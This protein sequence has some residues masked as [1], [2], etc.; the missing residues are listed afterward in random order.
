MTYCVAFL[1]LFGVVSCKKL[2]TF[3]PEE[4]AKNALIESLQ[5]SLDS[6]SVQSQNS[7]LMSTDVNLFLPMSQS[8]LIDPVI[9][10]QIPTG[11]IS[12]LNITNELN[13]QACLKSIE[14]K[15]IMSA[16]ISSCTFDDAYYLIDGDESR[17]SSYLQSK[18]E[19]AIQSTLK[20]R[21]SSL[22]IGS[23]FEASYKNFQNAYNVEA[24]TKVLN[25]DLAT[26]L[27]EVLTQRYFYL[28]SVEEHKIRT[29]SSHQNSALLQLV[30]GDK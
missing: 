26:Y 4:D 20:E 17:A 19:Y 27:S 29:E 10:N 13:S 25:I 7:T 12:L 16:A 1:V 22:I 14:L 6:A 24:G 21:I 8:N 15:P 28:M 3:I 9:L 2:K 18:K 5:L 30:F 11:S 23:N